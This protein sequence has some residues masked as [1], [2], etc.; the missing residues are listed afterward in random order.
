MKKTLLLM[1]IVMIFICGCG[2][3]KI[4]NQEENKEPSIILLPGT[5]ISGIK[6]GTLNIEYKEG[7]SIININ[8]KNTTENDINLSS[9]IMT[10][11][12]DEENETE[13]IAY[14]SSIVTNGNIMTEIKSTH[15]LR[16]VKEVKYELVG[17]SFE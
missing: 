15:D 3:K 4:D 5:E 13:V 11:I 2:N 12:D 6:I 14:V 7:V 1:T 8:V 17:D 10:F 16:N 9:I